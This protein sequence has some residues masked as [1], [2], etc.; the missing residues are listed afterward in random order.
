MGKPTIH[1]GSSGWTYDDWSGT[2][3]PKDVKGVQR[4]SF[5]AERFSAV[6]INATFYRIPTQPMIDAWNRRL[7]KTY[8]LAVKG[9]RTITHLKKLRNCQEPLSLFCER[10]LQLRA[11]RV[12]LWQLPPSLHVDV[13]RLDQFLAQL[14]RRVRHA[15][16]FR[17]ESWW[18]DRD[19]A[20]TLSRH[21]TAQAAVSH[22][23]LPRTVRPT[24]D[25]L[26]VRFHGVGQELYRYDYSRRELAAW[27]RRLRPHLPGRTLYA[28]FN[29]TYDANAPRNAAA[30][31]ELLSRDRAAN[32]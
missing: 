28:F 22:P 7:P 10:V 1:I 11:L 30:L 4:L 12:M 31:R 9:P 24:T 2:F 8:Q 17:H 21:R 29:N 32:P 16:E 25:F 15:V 27:A 6:E 26:Y 13:E 19:T 14:P 5:Y 18:G 20:A 23:Q 3:Y